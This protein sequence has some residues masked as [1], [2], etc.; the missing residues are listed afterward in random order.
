M[1]EKSPFVLK[2]KLIPGF[3]NYAVTNTG[4]VYKMPLFVGKPK[5]LKTG[6]WGDDHLRVRLGKAGKFY[7]HRLVLLAFVG[8]CP[9]GMECRHLDGDYLNN[10]LWNLCWGTRKENN[11]DTVRHGTNYLKLTKDDVLE[12]RYRCESGE[13]HFQVA[14]DKGVTRGHVT[15]IVNREVW[16]HV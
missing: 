7:V 6:L 16:K 3:D 13:S 5:L 11:E 15:G 1:P 14:K 2:L 8:P 4:N 12:I 10:H 9:E